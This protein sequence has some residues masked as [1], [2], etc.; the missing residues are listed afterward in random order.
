MN[1]Y[2]AFWKNRMIDIEGETAYKA[3]GNAQKEFQ[4]STRKKVKQ[5]DV[6]VYIVGKDGQ[7]LAPH[8][9]DF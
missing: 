5:E 9:A 7:P 8:I 1:Q 2:K 3:Q 4:K 6:T